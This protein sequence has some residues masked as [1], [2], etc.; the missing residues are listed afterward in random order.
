VVEKTGLLHCCICSATIPSRS[1]KA[2]EGHGGDNP[3]IK[4]LDRYDQFLFKQMAEGGDTLDMGEGGKKR[5]KNKQRLWPGP[6]PL[7]GE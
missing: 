3:I 4:E 5:L 6:S 7:R 1:K 2:G